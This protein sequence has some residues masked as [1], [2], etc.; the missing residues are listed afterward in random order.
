MLV[1]LNQIIVLVYSSHPHTFNLDL[2]I[3]INLIFLNHPI[4]LIFLFSDLK[5]H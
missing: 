2:I 1:Y 4:E 5:N 3:L